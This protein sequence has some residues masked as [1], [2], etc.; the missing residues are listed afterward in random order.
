MGCLILAIVLYTRS[1]ERQWISAACPP[2]LIRPLPLW[3]F[4][5]VTQMWKKSKTSCPHSPATCSP[6][7][8]LGT[9]C[10]RPGTGISCHHHFISHPHLMVKFPC[11]FQPSHCINLSPPDQDPSPLPFSTSHSASPDC[12]LLAALLCVPCPWAVQPIKCVSV[13]SQFG[14]RPWLAQEV[15]L[16]AMSQTEFSGRAVLQLWWCH[17]FFF[18]AFRVGGYCQG[19]LER[20]AKLT[21]QGWAWGEEVPG[22]NLPCLRLDNSVEWPPRT[23]TY[24]KFNVLLLPFPWSLTLFH[25][26]LSCCRELLRLTRTWGKQYFIICFVWFFFFLSFHFSY[27]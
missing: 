20:C 10:F 27:P 13:G 22:W 24:H 15:S 18:P 6:Y 21:V 1:S 16:S 2:L 9:F 23:K 17:G 19:V 8:K 11:T 12:S 5:S 7:C 4:F 25:W 3:F 14:E 26:L